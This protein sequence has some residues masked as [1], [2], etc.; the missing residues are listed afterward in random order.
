VDPDELQR[1][2]ERA[3]DDWFEPYL[4]PRGAMEEWQ[5]RFKKIKRE[6]LRR[7]EG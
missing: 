4:L 5:K 7:L 2:T 3:I 6:I 1:L